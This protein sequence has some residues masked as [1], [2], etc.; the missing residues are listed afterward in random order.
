MGAGGDAA[1]TPGEV[2]IADRALELFLG[3][4]IKNPKRAP[5]MRGPIYEA[6]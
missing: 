3:G 5:Q 6:A 4:G 1:L 2:V